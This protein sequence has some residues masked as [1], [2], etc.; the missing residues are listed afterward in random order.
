MY[1]PNDLGGD[2][3]RKLEARNFDFSK[4]HVIDFHIDFDVWPPPGEAINLLKLKFGNV[5]IIE[6]DLEESENNG[7]VVVQVKDRVSYK[8]VKRMQAE[9]TEIMREFFGWCDSWGVMIDPKSAK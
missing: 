4:E 3:L 5:E 8:S 2:V 7:Y 6:D 9:L 1:W